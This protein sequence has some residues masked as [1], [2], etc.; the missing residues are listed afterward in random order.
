LPDGL[1]FCGLITQKSPKN[2][3]LDRTKLEDVH[4]DAE[5]HNIYT[6]SFPFPSKYLDAAPALAPTL[7][8]TKPIFENK[9][10]LKKGLEKNFL[11][12]FYDLNCF[13]R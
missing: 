6:A 8:N 9:E 11:L 7:L 4:S 10:N 1:N 12:I 5:P 13:K 3:V 2:I